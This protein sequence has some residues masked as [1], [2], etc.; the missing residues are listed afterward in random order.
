[1]VATCL[2][3]AMRWLGILMMTIASLSSKECSLSKYIRS[4]S[5]SNLVVSFTMDFMNIIIY[6]IFYTTISSETSSLF[7]DDKLLSCTD[8]FSFIT[9]DVNNAKQVFNTS[10]FSFIMTNFL[11]SGCT[12]STSI[13]VY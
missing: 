2:T 9:K 1:M 7:E 6:T 11:S 8:S 12:Y 13:Y 3:S 4:L 5:F 10:L